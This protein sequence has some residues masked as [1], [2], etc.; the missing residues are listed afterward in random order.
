MGSWC[1]L[2]CTKTNLTLIRHCSVISVEIFFL[3]LS[4]NDHKGLLQ[5]QSKPNLNGG[6]SKYL[7][8]VIKILHS[9]RDDD[10]K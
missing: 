3:S 1:V 5:K 4:L 10:N 8:W 2:S 9:G 6:I 7:G